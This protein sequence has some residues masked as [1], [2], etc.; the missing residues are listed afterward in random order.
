LKELLNQIINQLQEK[1]AAQYAEVRAQNLSQNHVHHGKEG[2]VGSSEAGIENGAA[3]GCSSMG[4][5]VCFVGS[6]DQKVD[7]SHP[8]ACAWRKPLAAT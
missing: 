4:H 7:R 2:R 3:L 1:F 6:L 5:G 8:D